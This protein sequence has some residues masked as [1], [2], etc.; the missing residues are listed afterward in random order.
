MNPDNTS[1]EQKSMFWANINFY[2]YKMI[3]TEIQQ[4]CLAAAKK[5]HIYQ[6]TSLAA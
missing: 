6:D 1:A 5:T 3:D 2:R 4:H